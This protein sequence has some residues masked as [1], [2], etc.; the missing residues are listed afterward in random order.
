MI[1]NSF[2]NI[3]KKANTGLLS[4]CLFANDGA[5]LASSRSGIELSIREYQNTCSDFGL[6][7]STAKTKHMV[8]G[9]IV[10]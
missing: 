7:V 1:R 8:T 4:D 3:Q 2:T 6:S 10:T 5:L 9:R